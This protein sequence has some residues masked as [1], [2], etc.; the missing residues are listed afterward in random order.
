MKI[1]HNIYSNSVQFFSSFERKEDFFIDL[2]EGLGLKKPNMNFQDYERPYFD[3]KNYKTELEHRK[4]Q[5]S[6]FKHVDPYLFPPNL[7]YKMP[8]TFRGLL[9]ETTLLSDPSLDVFRE[10]K[11]YKAF[12]NPKYDKNFYIFMFHLTVTSSIVFSKEKISPSLVIYKANIYSFLSISLRVTGFIFFFILMYIPFMDNI[13]LNFFNN[14]FY[15]I[16]YFFLSFFFNEINM[17]KYFVFLPFMVFINI[18]LFL[19]IFHVIYGYMHLFP[20]IFTTNPLIFFRTWMMLSFSYL[21][22]HILI[23]SVYIYFPVTFLNFESLYIFYVFDFLDYYLKGLLIILSGPDVSC[24]HFLPLCQPVVNFFNIFFKNI[25]LITLFTLFIV[26]FRELN[27][28]YKLYFCDKN[29]EDE[30]KK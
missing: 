24:D 17:L 26:V 7:D 21:F 22:L 28:Y 29:K 13:F 12:V 1:F 10:H 15:S 4:R 25:I 30:F 23:H 6:K 14:I 2:N 8:E 9:N 18:F 27:N 11:D 19:F 16:F 3:Y 20:V 5:M